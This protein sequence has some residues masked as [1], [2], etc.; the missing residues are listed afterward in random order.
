M[1]VKKWLKL[2]MRNESNFKKWDILKINELH[3]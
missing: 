1:Q 3:H 2:L